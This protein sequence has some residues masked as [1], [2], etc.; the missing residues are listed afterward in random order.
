MSIWPLLLL[1]A[2]I[3]L[4]LS[5]IFIFFYRSRPILAEAIVCAVMTTLMVL[6]CLY[7]V[8]FLAGMPGL[9]LVLEGALTGVAIAY[10]GRHRKTLLEAALRARRFA[11]RHPYVSAGLVVGWSYLAAL[12]LLIPPSSNDGLRTHLARVML[13]Q[14]E[15]TLFLDVVTPHQAHR[16]V[17]PVGFDILF[18]AQLRF[19]CD[20]GVALFSFLGYLALAFGVYS[21]ARRCASARASLCA[22]VVVSS[23]PAVVYHSTSTKNDGVTAAVAIFCCVLAGRLLDQP[24]ARD[25]V[26]LI[27]GTFFGVSIKVSYLGF[28]LPFVLVSGYLLLKRH[29]PVVWWRLY[30]ENRWVFISALLPALVLSQGWLFAHNR[31]LTGGFFGPEEF[32]AAHRNAHGLWGAFANV[33]RYAHEVPDFLKLGD[34]L[35]YHLFGQPLSAGLQGLY[36]SV[37]ADVFGD[38]GA[39]YPFRVTWS[40]HESKAWFGPLGFLVVLPSCAVAA[41]RGPRF[42]RALAMIL[43]AY[44]FIVA[45]QVAW[46][47]WNGRFFAICFAAGGAC[48]AWVLDRWKVRPWAVDLLFVSSFLMLTYAG[49]FNEKKPLFPLVARFDLFLQGFAEDNIWVQARGGLDRYYY[50]G[51]TDALESFAKTVPAGARVGVFSSDFSPFYHYLIRRPDV[52]FLPLAHDVIQ[53]MVVEREEVPGLDYLLCIGLEVCD[54]LRIDDSVELTKSCY[55]IDSSSRNDF[56][57]YALWEHPDSERDVHAASLELTR[58]SRI[59]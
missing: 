43:F 21:L 48:V 44:F 25:L 22:V 56:C 55:V 46:M 4:F 29:R 54:S 50:Y 57:L 27:L 38:A 6:S 35:G 12:A 59:G 19:H 16:S 23:M 53:D 49:G 32:V 26:L 45:W 34:R 17:Y 20:Y 7:Q 9:S 51:N 41:L 24:N 11:A 15:N 31:A 42:L 10:A 37:F 30:S 40:T 13:F 2:E 39:S 14:Q 28:A 58:V 52:R 5:A 18:H 47:E 8:C 1:L 3:G 36:N 33:V